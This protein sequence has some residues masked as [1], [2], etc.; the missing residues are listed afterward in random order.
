MKKNLKI[1]YMHYVKVRASEDE[2]NYHF[3][4]SKRLNT[5]AE[6]DFRDMRDTH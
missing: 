3:L 4:G 2:R 6:H 5:S 1:A